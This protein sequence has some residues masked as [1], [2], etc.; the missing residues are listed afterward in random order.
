MKQ[1]FLSKGRII[2]REIAQPICKSGCVLMRTSASCISAGTE[3]SGINFSKKSLLSIAKEKPKTAIRFA[4]LILSRGFKFVLNT[5]KNIRGSDFGYEMG[6]SAAGVVVELGKGVEGFTIGQRIAAVGTKVANH[7]GYNVVPLNLAIPIPDNISDAEAATAALGGIAFQGVRRLAPLPGDSV[8]VMGLG[9][10]GHLVVQILLASGCS[11]TGIDINN[12][13][14]SEAKKMYGIPTLN[15]NDPAIV[16]KAIMM[17]N[18]KGYDGVIFTAATSS[19]EPMS[20]CFNML[21]KKGVFVLVGVSGMSIKRDDIYPKE[22]D[23]RIATSY[24]PG[25][26]DQ[27]YESKGNDYP[28]EYVRFTIKRNIAAYFELIASG[29]ISISKL[30]CNVVPVDNAKLAFERLTK[31]NPPLLSIITYNDDSKKSTKIILDPHFIVDKKRICYAI[32]GTGGYAKNM[33]LPIL[34]QMQD[35]YQ[36]KAVMNQSPYS[37]AALATQYR[38]AYY[39]LNVQDIFDD[40]DIQMVIICTRHNSHADYVCSALRAGKDVFVEKPLALNLSELECIREELKK[41]DRLLMVGFNRRFSTYMRAIKEKVKNRKSPLVIDYSMCAGYIPY[42]NWIHSSDGG[43]RIIGE[44]CHIIDT[45]SYL[46]T[47][48]IKSIHTTPVNFSSSYFR[49]DDNVTITIEYEDSSIAVIRY[50][51]CNAD[52]LPKERMKVFCDGK[53]Y[54]LDNYI[55]LKGRGAIRKRISSLDSDKGQKDILE[56]WYQSIRNRI[57]A[58]SFEEMYETTKATFTIKNDINLIKRGI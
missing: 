5:I 43:G 52:S 55:K 47:S 39:T 37:P 46:T 14:L 54:H 34:S 20:A 9:F 7:A 36:L 30:E 56:A 32:I 40:P 28:D 17:N 50:V 15:G 49:S 11:V 33:H 48:R 44:C 18:G 42:D 45:C 25:R 58:I 1:V 35:R 51:S 26:Y 21:R 3:M 8:V 38:A 24:G 23:F 10:L 29:R 6:Y 16:E 31:P 53:S 57:S 4:K 22:I 27:E 13:R 41:T 12:S 19:N 2:T